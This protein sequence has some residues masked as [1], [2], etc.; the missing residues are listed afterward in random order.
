LEAQL[1]GQT[2]EQQLQTAQRLFELLKQLEQLGFESHEVGLVQEAQ[3]GY[4]AL[5]AFMAGLEAQT[6]SALDIAKAQ[7][8]AAQQQLAY[9]EQEL[10]WNRQVLAWQQQV[11]RWNEQMVREQQALLD[12]NR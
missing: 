7:L 12:W 5:L 8:E 11:L 9:Q 4:E 6:Q 10:E 1:A 2:P 3:R